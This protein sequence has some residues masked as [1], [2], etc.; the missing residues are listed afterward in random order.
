VLLVATVSIA[1]P[2]TPNGTVKTAF[3]AGTSV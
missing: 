2:P 3:A 1:Q